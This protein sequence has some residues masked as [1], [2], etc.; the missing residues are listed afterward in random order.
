[1][2]SRPLVVDLSRRCRRYVLRRVVLCRI[3]RGVAGCDA[4]VCSYVSS[5]VVCDMVS[6]LVSSR[7]TYTMSGGV[8]DGDNEKTHIHVHTCIIDGDVNDETDNG[9]DHEDDKP[10]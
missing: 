9:M 4:V 8:Y 10:W 1:M 5:H 6:C 2:L 7:L 3:V